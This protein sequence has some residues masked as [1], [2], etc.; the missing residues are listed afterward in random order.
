MLHCLEV[1]ALAVCIVVCM[2]ALTLFAYLCNRAWGVW[3]RVKRLELSLL[4]VDSKIIQ[5]VATLNASLA[6]RRSEFKDP[7]EPG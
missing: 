1:A 3:T 5:L 2:L 7:D 6:S 4:E